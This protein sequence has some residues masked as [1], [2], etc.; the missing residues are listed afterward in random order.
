[1]LEPQPWK[2]YESNRYVTEVTISLLSFLKFESVMFRD[3]LVSKAS[4][5]SR[6]DR[7]SM[8]SSVTS[9]YVGGS[10]NAL[11]ICLILLL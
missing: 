10:T 7:C 3:L 8:F 2:S 11:S 6:R 1:M 5:T 4:P 9:L